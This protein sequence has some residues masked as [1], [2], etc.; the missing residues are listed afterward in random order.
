M[1]G[2]RKAGVILGYANIVVKNLVNL[3][4]TPMLLSF[5]GQAEYGVYQSSYSF[6]FSLT[7]LSFGFSQSYVRFYAR[8]KINGTDEDI[9]RLNGVYLVMY[10]IVSLL[11]FA[12]GLVLSFNAGVLFSSGFS[13]DQKVLASSIMAIMSA[14]I[15]LTL[16]DTVFDSYILAREEFR[17]QQSRQL[18]T[19]LVTPFVAYLLLL[20]GFGVIG[21]AI[22]NLAVKVVLLFMNGR[23]CI[24]EKGMRFNIRRFDFPLFREIAVFS[25]WIFANEVCN[26]V[27]QNVPNILLGALGNASAVAVFAISVQIRS[28]FGSL[29]MAVSNVFRPEINRIVAETD[30]N[31]RLTDIMTC[32]GRYQLAIVCWILGGFALLGTFFIERWAGQGFVASYWLILLM[33][34]AN[35]VPMVQTVGIEIQ[36]AKNMHKTRSIAMLIS[37]LGN[38]VLTV[39]LVPSMGYWAPAIA[40][41]ASV[42]LCNGVFMNWYYQYRV[43]MDMVAFWQRCIPIL[44]ASAL[45]SA[46][47]LVCSALLPVTSWPSFV[48]WGVAYS[49][50][51]AAISWRFVL[52]RTEREILASVFSKRKS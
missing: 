40:Y 25:I 43:G 51:F 7:A 49:L 13:E 19:V 24:R 41:A 28:V 4:Y 5:V 27:N 15:A 32:V 16:F 17:F 12:L 35:L 1:F 11:A 34:L 48:A 2:Q 3:V 42:L 29:S 52:D 36:R 33:S 9:R 30:D 18:A 23:F 50:L 14:T 10:V 8:K 39:C 22:A 38:V 46:A 20:L 44:V 47:C 26:I 31:Q 37:A 45:I 6:V 21:A